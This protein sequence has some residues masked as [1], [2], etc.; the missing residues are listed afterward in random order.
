MENL[1]NYYTD[2]LSLVTPKEAQTYAPQFQIRHETAQ[3]N[4]ISL[5]DESATALEKW[6]QEN[7]KTNGSALCSE[8]IALVKALVNDPGGLDPLVQAQEFFKKLGD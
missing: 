7:Y 6:L 2:Q 1:S 3:T 5:N 8:A 4:W